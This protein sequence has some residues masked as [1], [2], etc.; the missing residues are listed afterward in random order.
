MADPPAAP[1][2][3]VL[4][5]RTGQA[6]AEHERVV[7]QQLAQSLAQV[8]RLP[9]LGAASMLP[10]STS[11][12]LIPD[13]T[14]IA[15]QPGIATE[16]DLYGAVVSH[17]FVA[18]KA[19][20]HPWWTA[21]PPLR[22]AGAASS[23]HVPR[24]QYCPATVPSTG[25]TP[26]APADCFCQPGR[27]GPNWW[28]VGPVGGSAYCTMN[29]NCRPGWMSCP[30]ICSASRGWYSSRISHRSAPTASVSCGSGPGV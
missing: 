5:L 16:L 19:I 8:L 2:R 18:G 14:L 13:A 4:L 27:C 11:C 12:Y 9:F 10:N 24:G 20:S 1:V 7:Q 17:P 22:R 30:M 6:C 15:P 23:L 28:R 3:G 29:G 21:P 25:V 26:C